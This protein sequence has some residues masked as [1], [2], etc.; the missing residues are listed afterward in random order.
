MRCVRVR[1]LHEPLH[2]GLQR[3][4]PT[5]H[6]CVQRV[7]RLHE[8]DDQLHRAAHLYV[9]ANGSRLPVRV[10]RRLR[11]PEGR[12]RQLRDLSRRHVGATLWTRGVSV[13]VQEREPASLRLGHLLV[14]SPAQRSGDYP[15]PSSVLLCERRGFVVYA[16]TDSVPLQHF[17]AFIQPGGAQLSRQLGGACSRVVPRDMDRARMY[18]YGE[19]HALPTARSEPTGRRLVP[20]AMSSQRGG[21]HVDGSVHVERL[22]GTPTTAYFMFSVPVR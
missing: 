21:M 14:R 11:R 16:N 7:A 12:G 13:Y 8:H 5:T 9:H 19:V 2:G 10:P 15:A 3:R 22:S 18:F 4:H 6:V 1:Q 20:H 17:G